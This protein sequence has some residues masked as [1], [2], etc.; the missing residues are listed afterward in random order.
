MYHFNNINYKLLSKS[1][2]IT[3]YFIAAEKAA[4]AFVIEYGRWLR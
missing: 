3:K 1:K 2:D 4:L